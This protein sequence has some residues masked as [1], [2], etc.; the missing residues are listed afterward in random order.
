MLQLWYIKLRYYI[1]KAN[2][3]FIGYN[4]FILF[5]GCKKQFFN[6]GSIQQIRKFQLCPASDKVHKHMLKRMKSQTIS[7]SNVQL[8]SVN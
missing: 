1:R 7:S 2:I 5:N 6:W 8:F 3:S 4:A